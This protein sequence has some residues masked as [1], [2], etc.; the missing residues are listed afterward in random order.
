MRIVILF[1]SL[2][3]SL[4]AG[5]FPKE[6][7]HSDPQNP[8]IMAGAHVASMSNSEKIQEENYGWFLSI[9][10][11]GMEI[12]HELIRRYTLIAEPMGVFKGME[13]VAQGEEMILMVIQQ[14]DAECERYYLLTADRSQTYD[15][16]L[17]AKSCTGNAEPGYT[18]YRFRTPHELEQVWVEVAEAGGVDKQYP[19]RAFF[20]DRAGLIQS[21]SL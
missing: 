7:P 11:S 13:V 12:P 1:S 3:V 4:L 10:Q 21:R 9:V 6:T 18:T 15:Q 8:F 20:W 14:K 19:Q 17:V 16:A 5:N 2:L